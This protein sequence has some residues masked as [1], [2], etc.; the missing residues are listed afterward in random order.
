M[1]DPS[2]TS[3]AV[4]LLNYDGLPTGESVVKL[5]LPINL[6]RV[7]WIPF[8]GD[9]KSLEGVRDK[10]WISIKIPGFKDF[11]LLRMEEK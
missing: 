5:K 2:K 4:T 8:Q 11:A 9:K 10:D 6:E 1:V 7:E 3:Y